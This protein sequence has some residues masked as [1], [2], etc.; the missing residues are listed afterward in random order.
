MKTDDL[1]RVLAA[2]PEVEKT[3]L[4]LALVYGLIPGIAISIALYIW[5]LGPRPHLLDLIAEP[6]IIF[7]I[8]YPLALFACAGP[9]ALRLARPMGDPRPLTNVLLILLLLLAAAVALEL[10]ILPHDLWR[11][12]LIGHNAVVCMTIIPLMAA[13][14]LVGALIALHRGAPE[15]PSLAGATAGLLAGAFAATLYATHCPDDSPLFVATWYG[16]AILIVISVGAI[17]GSRVLRW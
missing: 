17:A 9:L 14:P 10:F 8:I 4:A 12:R 15:N 11:V 13:A 2:D 1:I 7:K 16:L 3:P 6:R 5:L